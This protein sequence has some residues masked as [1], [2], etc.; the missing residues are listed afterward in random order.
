MSGMAHLDWLMALNR[1]RRDLYA[2]TVPPDEV[3]RR[4]K[5]NKRARAS[6]RI[7]RGSR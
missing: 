3:T 7:N 2:G 5:R 6:R 4:R 1:V